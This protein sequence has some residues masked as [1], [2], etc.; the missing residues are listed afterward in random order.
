MHLG[1]HVQTDE[2]QVP[3]RYSS[4]DPPHRGPRFHPSASTQRNISS[5]NSLLLA[6]VLG[7]DHAADPACLRKILASNHKI[8]ITIDESTPLILT[9]STRA[10]IPELYNKHKLT[11]QLCHHKWRDRVFMARNDCFH[12]QFP[13]FLKHLYNRNGSR[14]CFLCIE[15]NLRAGGAALYALVTAGKQPFNRCFGDRA[16]KGEKIAFLTNRDWKKT[17]VASGAAITFIRSN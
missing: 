5:I 17:E 8:L 12:G 7:L 16:L 4:P 3:I 1:D 10:R 2:A 9:R 15:C 13:Q 14:G 11:H 6:V